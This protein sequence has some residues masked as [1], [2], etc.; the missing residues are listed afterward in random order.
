[1]TTT[2]A[3]F[4][5]E[6]P[7]HGE[8]NWD[9]DINALFQQITAYL[10]TINAA[11]ALKADLTNGKLTSSQLPT[12]TVNNTFG[13]ANQAA[14]LGLT[15]AVPGDAAIRADNG[16]SIWILTALPSSNLAN[17]TQV[18]P[19]NGVISVNGHTGIITGLPELSIDNVFTGNVSF[20]QP[21]TVP[22]ATA[23]THAMNRGQVNAAIA[24]ATSGVTSQKYAV[25]F[26]N[27]AVPTYSFTFTHNLG[28]A[29]VDYQLWDLSV[30][31]RQRIDDADTVS[32]TATQITLTFLD[33]PI[34][35]SR[36]LVVRS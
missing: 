22:N 13:A 23:D 7:D 20:T 31:P 26:G 11:L 17:W 28:T 24:S 5:K 27:T 30:T 33:A 21:V 9:G 35:N 4:N 10:G 6:L 15:A 3:P 32:V 25:S 18:N 2:G 12:Y 36:R 19:S 16:G 14:M 29:D 1:M 34:D 8:I